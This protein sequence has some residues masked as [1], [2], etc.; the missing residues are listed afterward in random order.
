M[1]A[2]FQKI[3]TLV[4][5]LFKRHEFKYYYISF[6]FRRFLFIERIKGDNKAITKKASI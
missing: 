2:A 3:E 1:E 4:N 5:E 6:F